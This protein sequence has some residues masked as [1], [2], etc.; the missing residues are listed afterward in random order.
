MKTFKTDA[1]FLKMLWNFCQFDVTRHAE[2]QGLPE[3]D[4]W[5]LILRRMYPD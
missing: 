1:K 5:K 4:S 2:K 3:L